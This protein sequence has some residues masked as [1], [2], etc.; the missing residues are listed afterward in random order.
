MTLY[1]TLKFLHIVAAAIALGGGLILSLYL[2]S[3][4]LSRDGTRLHSASSVNAW[5]GVRIFGPSYALVLA[6][7]IWTTL[8]G[9]W[10]FGDTWIAIG[11]VVLAIA[12][13]LG[14]TAHMRNGLAMEKAIA[15]SGPSSPAAMA[16]GRRECV[17]QLFELA[18]VIL[19]V[20]AMTAKP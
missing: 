5:A 8:E 15:D 3:A 1:E 7:G 9:G 19:A 16:I 13:V 11:I 6:F 14:P 12:F 17:V 2:L 18:L 20:W 4:V 10:D